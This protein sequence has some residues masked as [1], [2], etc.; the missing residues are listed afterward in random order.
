MKYKYAWT[1]KKVETWR[2]GGED[3]W[4]WLQEYKVGVRMCFLSGKKFPY[5]FVTELSGI[6]ISSKKFPRIRKAIKHL[7]NEH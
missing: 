5:K 4:V 6:C 3:Y 2:R 1:P 7:R